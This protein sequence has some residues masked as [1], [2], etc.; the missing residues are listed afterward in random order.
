MNKLRKIVYELILSTWFIALGLAAAFYP[1]AMPLITLLCSAAAFVVPAILNSPKTEKNN[2]S[3]LKNKDFDVT[4]NFD[5]TLNSTKD[6]YLDKEKHNV[7]NKTTVN[8]NNR[9]STQQNTE[10]EPEM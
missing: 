3:K 9:Q 2:K 5:T 1:A 10:Q 6:I 7:Y 4:K 8:N